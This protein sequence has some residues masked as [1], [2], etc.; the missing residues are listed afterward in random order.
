MD[1]RV[2]LDNNGFLSVN[3]AAT[4]RVRDGKILITDCPFAE[5]HEQAVG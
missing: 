5:T 3:D 4:L 1:A 2:L